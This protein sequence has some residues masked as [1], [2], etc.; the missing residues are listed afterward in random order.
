MLGTVLGQ[1]AC[2]VSPYFG[3]DLNLGLYPAVKH[4]TS[5]QFEAQGPKLPHQT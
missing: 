5:L 1:G 4:T 2:L 3:N